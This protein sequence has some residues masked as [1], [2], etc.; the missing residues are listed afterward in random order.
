MATSRKFV[1]YVASKNKTGNRWLDTGIITVAG[2]RRK[3]WPKQ[4]RQ[5]VEDIFEW[6]NKNLTVPPFRE[7]LVLKRWSYDA[8]CWFYKGAERLYRSKVNQLIRLLRKHGYVVKTLRVNYPGKVVYRDKYQVVAE[9][10]K[11]YL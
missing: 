9:T 7:N 2:L 8:V 5:Q 1:R 10:P 6:F 11:K 3:R 4:D